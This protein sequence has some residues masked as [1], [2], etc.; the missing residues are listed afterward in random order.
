MLLRRTGD[1]N[2]PYRSMT[3]PTTRIRDLPLER[4]GRARRLT[5]EHSG[6]TIEGRSALMTRFRYQRDQKM[7]VGDGR[8]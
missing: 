5:G 6:I 4:D 8:G 3:N 1:V 7:V 2:S